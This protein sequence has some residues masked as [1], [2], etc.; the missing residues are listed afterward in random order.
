VQ[1]VDAQAD[2]ECLARRAR[3]IEQRCKPA[4]LAGRIEDDVIGQ[5][6]DLGQVLGLVGSAIGRDLAAIGLAT[7]PRFEEAASTTKAGEG[8]RVRSKRAKAPGSPAL[9]SIRR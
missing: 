7:Q 6:E 1:R 4:V 2:V 3:C 8:T 9:V 5:P